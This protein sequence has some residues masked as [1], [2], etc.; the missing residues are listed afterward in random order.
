MSKAVYKYKP[1]CALPPGWVLEEHLAV[2]GI[3]KAAFARQ[4]GCSPKLIGEI[5]SGESSIDVETSRAFER[6]LGLGAEIWL[7]MDKDYWI[8][9]SREIAAQ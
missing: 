8:F 4:C 5:I 7:G 6:V 1:D 2:R 3:S 9:K